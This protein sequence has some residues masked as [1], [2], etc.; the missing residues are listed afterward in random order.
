MAKDPNDE[1]E[2]IEL[3]EPMG[4]ELP[5]AGAGTL[6]SGESLPMMASRLSVMESLV[7]LLTSNI[8]FHDFVREVLL[9][10]MKVV[11]CEAGSVLEVN[12]DDQTLF[13]RAAAGMSSDRVVRFVIPMGQG[14]AGH[15]AESRQVLVCSNMDESAIHLKSIQNAI[16]FDCRNLF[17]A[18]IVIRGRTYGVVEFLNRIGED[19][20]TPADAEIISYFC[21]MAGKAI[22]IR[23]MIGWARHKRTEIPGG[24]RSGNSE[25]AA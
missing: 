18:P 16:G 10:G 21:E 1:Q 22:E 23:L 9:L 2:L 25:D 17:A 8:S 5:E 12:H 3:E 4:V 13:F 19:S 15:V 11:R 14:I 7:R 24:S 20:F 6:F